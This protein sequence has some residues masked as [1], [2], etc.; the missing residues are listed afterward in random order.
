MH[1]APASECP[2]NTHKCHS[3]HKSQTHLLRCVR[4]F[5]MRGL[6]NSLPVNLKIKAKTK[7]SGSITKLAL[8]KILEI[9]NQWLKKINLSPNK[10]L[11]TDGLTGSFYQP[12]VQGQRWKSVWVWVLFFGGFF[13]VNFFLC[14]GDRVSLYSLGWPKF[15][16]FS[17]LDAR[18]MDICYHMQSKS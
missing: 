5:K 6:V 3:I 8:K 10:I 9:L 1:H 2:Q 17:L 18:I 14:F 16:C 12:N 13:F 4:Y 11:S 7:N 15:Y